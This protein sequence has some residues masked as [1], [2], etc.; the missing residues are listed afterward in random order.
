MIPYLLIWIEFRG[1]WWKVVELDL[2]MMIFEPL[3]H[4]LGFMCWVSI[5]NESIFLICFIDDSFEKKYESICCKGSFIGHK[6]HNSILGYSRCCID[7]ES[8]SSSTYYRGLS[9][10]SPCSTTMICTFESCL[11]SI[12]YFSLFSLCFIFNSWTKYF[13][14]FLYFF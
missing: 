3:I 14:P 10:D 7:S 6:L 5:E 12:E 4:F 8:C 1:V 2:F 13:S 9:F 11:I